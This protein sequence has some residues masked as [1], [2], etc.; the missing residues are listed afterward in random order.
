QGLLQLTEA[1]VTI[2]ARSGDVQLAQEALKAASKA[3]KDKTGRD[4]SA[5][6][7]DGLD[8]NSAGGVILSGHAGKINVNNTLDERLRLLEDKMLPEIRIDLFGPNENRK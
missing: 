3:Y 5:E 7:K 8:K 4:V 6:V 1:K 2:L